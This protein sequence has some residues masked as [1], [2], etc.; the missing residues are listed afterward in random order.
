MTFA[1]D[2]SEFD[3]VRLSQ[4][5]HDVAEPLP[6]PANISG[7][8]PHFDRFG[9]ARVVL[10]GEATCGSSEFQ[11]ARAAITRR[12]IERH[13]FAIVALEADWWDIVRLDHYVRHLP[14]PTDTAQGSES[15]PAWRW[16]NRETL[17]F[18]LWLREHNEGLPPA[19]RVVLCGLD[20]YAPGD[21]LGTLLACLDPADPAAA[22]EGRRHSALVMS[23][24]VMS[25]AS[26]QR[27]ASHEPAMLAQ[28]GERLADRLAGLDTAAAGFPDTDGKR[29]LMGAAAN[30]YRALCR[31][32]PD[33]RNLRARQM[34]TTLKSVMAHAAEP[35]RAVVWGHNVHIGNAAAN[36]IGWGGGFSLGELCRLAYGEEAVAIGMGT[37][38]G[39]FAAAEQ[40]GGVMGVKPLRPARSDSWE[41]VFRHAGFARS[42]TDWR[43]P[44]RRTLAETLRRALGERAIGPVHDATGDLCDDYFPAMLG[45]EFEAYVWFEE[46]TPVT[47]L[48][49][50][51]RDGGAQ[52]WPFALSGAAG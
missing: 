18:V 12:M 44:A 29:A 45:D 48:G 35:A 36:V 28:L 43:S 5:L 33:S 11:R 9:N 38:H 17:E 47:P 41:H 26:Q 20:L 42:L 37:D 16:R 27:P 2:T 52:T 6:H 7:F 50:Q 21:A 30:Y 31:G 4:V 32:M 1:T 10:L 25:Q 51:C 46:T 8:G 39:L 22:A 49:A 13:G 34:F 19:Q 15:F 14:V 40:W 24:A 3:L 23:Q